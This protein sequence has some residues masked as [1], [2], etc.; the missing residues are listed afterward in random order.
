MGES[1]SDSLP[2]GYVLASKRVADDRQP[3]RFMYREE[4]DGPDDSGWRLFSGEED[5]AYAD[6][7]A[8]IGLY[9]VGTIAE[10]DPSIVKHLLTPPPCAFERDAASDPFRVS[11]L[12]LAA[13]DE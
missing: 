10:I 11:D 13:E 2:S 9:T 4:P 12:G 7:P 1:Q 3:V 5:Q 6:N 8:N